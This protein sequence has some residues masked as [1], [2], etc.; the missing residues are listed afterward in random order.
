MRRL[1]INPQTL[2]RRTL[3]LFDPLE[4]LGIAFV[5]LADGIDATTPAG[6]LQMHILGSIV[7]K[8]HT[9]PMY[10]CTGTCTEYSRT[11][12]YWYVS[13]VPVGFFE[14]AMPDSSPPALS[15]TFRATSKCC[16]DEFHAREPT[17]QQE[18]NEPCPD[19]RAV[20]WIQLGKVCR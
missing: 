18:R 17:S 10:F 5:S 12:Q 19:A 4:A 8:T 3:L 16:L 7:S 1:Y 2:D 14:V 20:P 6:R 13:H 15:A 11:D 9:R